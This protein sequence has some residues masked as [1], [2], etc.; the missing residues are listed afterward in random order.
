VAVAAVQPAAVAPVAA[1]TLQD[2]IP[3]DAMH[4]GALTEAMVTLQ[5]R[6]L[7]NLHPTTALTDISPTLYRLMVHRAVQ[8]M[9]AVAAAAAVAASKEVA[10]PALVLPIMPTE[11]VGEVEGMEEPVDLADLVVVALLQPTFGVAAVHL[12]IAHSLAAVAAHMGPA[13]P[14]SLA[15]QAAAEQQVLQPMVVTRV[16]AELEVQAETA[17]RV[18]PDNR[19]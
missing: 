16:R 8:A 13:V 2:A 19:A 14:G 6:L 5:R 9:V 15:V 7:P 1:V 11:E 3:T 17:A 10:V 4:P 12:P 18:R